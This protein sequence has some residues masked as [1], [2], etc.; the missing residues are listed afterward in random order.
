M[1]P[2][3]SLR[4]KRPS[5]KS[6]G[7]PQPKRSRQARASGGTAGTREEVPPIDLPDEANQVS[8]P[9]GL[10]DQLVTRVADEVTK[11]LSPPEPPGNR[12]CARGPQTLPPAPMAPL[13][14]LSAAPFSATTVA[15]EPARALPLNALAASLVQGSLDTTQQ[16]LSG[17]LPVVPSDSRPTQLFKSCSLPIDA[18]VSDKI[19]AKIW[20]NEFVEFHILLMN[21]LLD[22][23]F[24][25]TVQNSDQGSTPSLCLEPLA[26][27]KRNQ[28]IDSWV[29]SFHVFVGV[30]TSKYPMRRPPS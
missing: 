15:A 20:N 14:T 4:A 10:L 8:L 21:P 12:P 26:K 3:R 28:S 24:I 9:A 25:L 27:A 16:V 7:Q 1:P 30:Y 22:N 23:K 11:R 17:E 29:N 5:V 6:M 13:S 18:R 19:K 2:R